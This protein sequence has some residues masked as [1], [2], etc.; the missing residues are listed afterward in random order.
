MYRAG[1]R[2]TQEGMIALYAYSGGNTIIG[3]VIV[4]VML[5]S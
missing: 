3:A 2:E 4:K 1:R 5:S